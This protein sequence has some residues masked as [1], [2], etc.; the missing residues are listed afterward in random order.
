MKLLILILPLEEIV[1]WKELSYMKAKVVTDPVKIDTIKH[2]I[3]PD[4]IK[5]YMWFQGEQI[6]S[7]IDFNKT[8]TL[9]QAINVLSNISRFDNISNLADIN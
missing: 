9:T 6:E 8:Q 4:N 3:L 2:K 7:I 1:S 5:P